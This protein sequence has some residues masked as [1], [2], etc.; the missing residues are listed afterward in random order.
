[1]KLTV[2]LTKE[3]TIECMFAYGVPALLPHELNMAAGYRSY[4]NKQVGFVSTRN[5]EFTY[6]DGYSELTDLLQSHNIPP[7][8]VV[9]LTI[10]HLFGFENGE[11][12]RDEGVWV[13]TLLG[14]I[15]VDHRFVENRHWLHRFITSSNYTIDL[16]YTE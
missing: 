5:D 6:V 1:M 3:E 7:S 15:K 11:I 9:N 4:V 16:S 12:T 8:D 2:N 13:V 14:F 10:D